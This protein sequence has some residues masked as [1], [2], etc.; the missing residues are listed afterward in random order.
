MNISRWWS[1]NT[2]PSWKSLWG[3]LLNRTTRKL[4][5]TEAGN[6]LLPQQQLLDDFSEL[7]NI[8]HSWDGSKGDLKNQ[9]T[10]RFWRALYVPAIDAYQR[11]FRTSK[12]WWRCTTVRS[13]SEAVLIVYIGDGSLDL[14]VVARKS[15][16][17][18][19]HLCISRLYRRIRWPQTIAELSLHRCL[20]YMDTPHKLLG[21]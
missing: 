6:L 3:T 16:K 9:R 12:S 2:W 8:P 5:M 4:S 18:I 21:V 10:H 7:E 20:H 11:E 15:P 14:A 1:A 19:V 13:T 17:P